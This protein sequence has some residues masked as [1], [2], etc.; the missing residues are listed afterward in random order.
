MNQSA[1]TPK[2]IESR[3]IYHRPGQDSLSAEKEKGRLGEKDS[4]GGSKSK[5]HFFTN[6]TSVNI[7][8]AFARARITADTINNRPP[9]LKGAPMSPS[10]LPRMNLRDIP[11]AHDPRAHFESSQASRPYGTNYNSNMNNDGVRPIRDI[12]NRGQT[13]P[14]SSHNYGH[15][16]QS[17]YQGMDI[18]SGPGYEHRD[19]GSAM[20]DGFLRERDWKNLQS[21]VPSWLKKAQDKRPNDLM[22]VSPPRGIMDTPSNALGRSAMGGAA[23]APSFDPLMD[24]LMKT[25][26]PPRDTAAAVAAARRFADEALADNDYLAGTTASR[27]NYRN[28][29]NNEGTLRRGISTNANENDP[30]SRVEPARANVN[31]GVTTSNFPAAN[32]GMPPR[33]GNTLSRNPS[34]RSAATATGRG[35][36]VIGRGGSTVGRG[37]STV[38]RGGAAAAR[39][40]RGGG[41][42]ARGGGAAE[43]IKRMRQQQQQQQEQQQQEEQEQVEQEQRLDQQHRQDIL[44]GGYG[45]G[46][47]ANANEYFAAQPEAA[48]GT[49]PPRSNSRF[50]VRSRISTPARSSYAQ[51]FGLNEDIGEDPRYL[52][53]TP[54][55][56]AHANGPTVPTPY[57]ARIKGPGAFPATAQ[58]YSQRRPKGR[59]T[60]SDVDDDE[61]DMISP[62]LARKPRPRQ[63]SN[64]TSLGRGSLLGSHRY[65]SHGSASN[66]GWDAYNNPDDGGEHGTVHSFSDSF[67]SNSSAGHDGDVGRDSPTLLKRL[68]RNIAAGWAGSAGS[69]AERV[70]FVFFMIYF[71]V[72][73][74]FVVV[75]AFVFRLLVSLIIGP[76]YSGVRETV[77]L[78]ISLWRMLSPGSS[79]DT[80]RSM[81]GVLTGF[82]VVALSVVV[83]Q[84]GT[85]T[86]SGLSSV[87][88]HILGGMWSSSLS[89]RPPLS[90]TPPAGLEP[91]TDEEID[92]LGGQG[93]AAVERL[94]NVEQTLRHLYGL[95]DTLRSYRD[96]ETQ[97][98]RE[99]LKRMQQEKQTLVDANRGEKQRVDN[100]EREY[101]NIKRDIKAQA[102][103]STDA[104]KH[105]KEIENLKKRVDQLMRGGTGKGA[106][107]GLEE[108]RKLVNDAIGK[109]E[110]ELKDMLKPGWLTTDGDAAY[111]NVARMIEDALSRYANDR[112]GK[113]DFALSSAGARIIPGLTSPTFE[114][115]V[116]SFSQRIWRKLGMVSSQPPATILDPNTHVGECWPMLGSSGQVA[117][118][119]SQPVLVSDFAIEH[120]AKSVAIDWRSAPRQIEVWGY[121]LGNGTSGHAYS[122]AIS[123]STDPSAAERD[124]DV[125]AASDLPLTSASTSAEPAHTLSADPAG[126]SS[127]SIPQYSESSSYGVGKLERL[128][129]YEYEPSDSSSLQIFRPF[130]SAASDSGAARVQTLVL[131]VKSNWGHPGH[132]CLYR[133]RVHGHRAAPPAE[134][135]AP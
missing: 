22:Q 119:L 98:V 132:T 133:F 40:G 107:P 113:T 121:V 61:A 15:T 8:T 69:F 1:Y 3:D 23:S 12:T 49:Y 11:D 120:V 25:S 68:F 53:K 33:T 86:L 117:I 78:P 51:D 109:Q 75:G 20:P 27:G 134:A 116:R 131:K 104:S 63:A 81:T 26:H 124:A 65:L 129:W 41:A 112:L 14:Y 5:A 90:I 72:K 21:G 77:L 110:R 54:T 13:N 28:I 128:A 36:S 19:T 99:S 127:I 10:Q 37:G 45:G 43:F 74:T 29:N 62:S 52:R 114:P 101:L 16:A 88:G 93:S 71:L 108:V 47:R 30:Y 76:V 34:A 102:T 32:S 42:A 50:S 84:Y 122:T 48:D 89:V 87:P 91:L 18:D 39:G 35:G 56:A 79:R 55:G 115:P 70:S 97:E 106:G 82:L 94:V 135:A 103:K 60:A 125:P 123:Q 64:A 24:N 80:T 92:R 85:S 58:R 118:H 2:P 67:A 126:L 96:E 95:L 7:A 66:R 4:S 46:M 31:G 130:G 105:V 100:L 57:T 83:S 44:N 17:G 73:E 9:H 59:N 6:L 111:A 38:G